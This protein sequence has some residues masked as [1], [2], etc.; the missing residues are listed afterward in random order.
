MFHLKKKLEFLKKKKTFFQCTNTCTKTLYP[1]NYAQFDLKFSTDRSQND[2]CTA[3]VNVISI[4]DFFI[5]YS[6]QKMSFFSA[7]WKQKFSI[8]PNEHASG[9]IV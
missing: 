8:P 3:L 2:V 7:F 6:Y 4:F 5:S 1:L 9:D